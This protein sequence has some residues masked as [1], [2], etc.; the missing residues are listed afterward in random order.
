MIDL[1]HDLSE[2]VVGFAGSDW[3][4]LVLAITA[5]TES[6]FFPIPPDPLLVGVALAQQNL[7]I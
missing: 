6:I 2:W 3:A 4:V 7:A 1:L 5:F